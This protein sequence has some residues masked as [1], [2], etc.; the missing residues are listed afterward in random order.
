M[1]LI[2]ALPGHLTVKRVAF[3][4]AIFANETHSGD[5]GIYVMNADGSNVTRLTD[6]D[7]GDVDPSWSPDGEK[8]AFCQLIEIVFGFEI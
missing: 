5:A 1:Q 7:A 2:A 3:N 4:S 6:N 8:I